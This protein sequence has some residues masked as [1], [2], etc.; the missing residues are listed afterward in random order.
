MLYG[1][2]N[3]RGEGGN[4]VSTSGRLS[5][6]NI[7]YNKSGTTKTTNGRI[8]QKP[9]LGSPKLGRTT[10][11]RPR[12]IKSRLKANLFRLDERQVRRYKI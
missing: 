3:T 1:I 5:C 9:K 12:F 4:V 11:A 6:P 2:N 10:P 8:K 7:K